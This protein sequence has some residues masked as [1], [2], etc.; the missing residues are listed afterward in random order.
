MLVKI[1]EQNTQVSREYNWSEDI[2]LPTQEAKDWHCKYKIEVDT[3]LI[4]KLTKNSAK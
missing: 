1:N 4:Q 3:D 2:L